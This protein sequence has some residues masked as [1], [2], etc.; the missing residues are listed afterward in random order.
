MPAELFEE[1]RLL[2]EKNLTPKK[3]LINKAWLE[4]E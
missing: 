1:W 2:V 3:I 4:I